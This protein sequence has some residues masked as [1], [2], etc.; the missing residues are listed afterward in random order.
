MSRSSGRRLLDYIRR[1]DDLIPDDMPLIGH[2]DDALLVELSWAEFA[3]EVQDY[4][5]YC[6]FIS[7]S[8]VRG[9]A[10]ER[11]VV[12]ESACLAEASQII[13]RQQVRERG[14]ARIE[15]LEPTVPGA[16]ETSS[17]R[18]G[19]AG[20]RARAPRPFPRAGSRCQALFPTGLRP[21]LEPCSR[22]PRMAPTFVHL[23]LHSEYSLIDSTLRIAQLVQRC[24][25]LG[26]PAVAVTDA[27][28]LFALV[29]FYKAAEAA[30]LKPMA[31]ADLW[32][33]DEGQPPA[34]LT[35]L[36]QNRAG[37]LSLSRLITRAFLEGHRGDFVAI[38]PEWL[39]AEHAGL[40]V[41][42]GRDK[43]DRARR[44]PAGRREQALRLPAG[45]AAVLRRP[46]VPGTDAHRSRR[47][48]SLQCPGA[49]AGR[50]P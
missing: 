16:T 23:H 15:P 36:C 47:R 14:Y 26:Q 44:S 24:V 25:E 30:G 39:L 11:R 20:F 31:G 7:E 5:D 27:S 29:K 37:F 43:P 35:V 10:E 40:I 46:A 19:R 13:H 22:L 33:A 45:L 2:L 34:R 3:G 21:K 42:A 17:R 12:W 49:G 6:R 32:V 1:I 41:L 50:A 9:T 18:S 28:N 4:L 8:H 48:G 38:K